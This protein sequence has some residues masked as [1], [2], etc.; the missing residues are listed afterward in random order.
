MPSRVRMRSVEDGA[1]LAPEIVRHEPSLALRAGPD[2]LDVLRALAPAA[3]AM[4]AELL[5]AEV[6]AGQAGAV[7][8]LARAAGFERT[9]RRADLAGVER[10]VVAWR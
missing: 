10:V 2:G 6:G 7:A 8:D 3:A 1:E 4:G 5:A 9:E